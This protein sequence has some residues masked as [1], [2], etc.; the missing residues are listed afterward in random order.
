MT[1]CSLV[2]TG[3]SN[4][5]RIVPCLTCHQDSLDRRADSVSQ[6]VCVSLC[7]YAI[8]A[9]STVSAT[10]SGTMIDPNRQCEAVKPVL[11]QQA[12]DIGV[13]DD[14]VVVLGRLQK[15]LLDKK[16]PAKAGS[17]PSSLKHG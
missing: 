11:M 15:K 1:P 13:L 8:T 14:I 9:G 7:V 4:V 5:I 17:V 6:R 12:V 2:S 16:L 3:C 10:D